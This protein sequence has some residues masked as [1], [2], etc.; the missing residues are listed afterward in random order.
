MALLNRP[1]GKQ[2]GILRGKVFRRLGDMYVCYLAGA[3]LSLHFTSSR[4]PATSP[5][6]CI[7]VQRCSIAQLYPHARPFFLFLPF[8][9][10]ACRVFAQSCHFH[11][12]SVLPPSLSCI[13]HT[14]HVDAAS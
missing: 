10:R 4:L 13:D 7:A 8:F 2:Q 3:G 6:I 14:S 5:H 9:F 1:M 11:T 12:F